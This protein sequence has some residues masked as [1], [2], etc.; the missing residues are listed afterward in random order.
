MLGWGWEAQ[1][2]GEEALK[3]PGSRKF[4]MFC[5]AKLNQRQRGIISLFFWVQEKFLHFH[6]DF[7]V[8]RWHVDSPD[9]GSWQTL[10]LSLLFSAGQWNQFLAVFSLILVKRSPRPAP[11]GWRLTRT[12]IFILFLFCKH[13][14]LSYNIPSL[15][16][17]FFACSLLY[18]SVHHVY[19]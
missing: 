8:D 1:R 10:T 15:S 7:V 4:V 2:A 6:S 5:G 11:R 13:R 9:K 16:F 19:R 18:E 17:H 3:G 12:F 14:R